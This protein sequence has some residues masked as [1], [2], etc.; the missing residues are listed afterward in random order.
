M[1]P[2]APPWDSIGQDARTFSASSEA[3]APLAAER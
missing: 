2:L 3:T 1:T